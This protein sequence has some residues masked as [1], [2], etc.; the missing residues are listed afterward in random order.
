DGGRLV[1]SLPAVPHID[2][3]HQMF[4]GFAR[5]L[6]RELARHGTPALVVLPCAEISHFEALLA[7]VPALGID[8]PLD[9][10]IVACLSERTRVLQAPGCAD[11]AT[12]YQ[13]LASGSPFGRIFL[14]DVTGA[15]G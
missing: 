4:H 2:D 15:A 13:R 14:T 12:L 3:R 5:W 8:R 9:I 10:P 1:Q 6:K 7:M 11:A